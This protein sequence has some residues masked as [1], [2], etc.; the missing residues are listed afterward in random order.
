M[1]SDSYL[2]CSQRPPRRA[3]VFKHGTLQVKTISLPTLSYPFRGPRTSRI[4]RV[5]PRRGVRDA[6]ETRAADAAKSI[7]SGV[8]NPRLGGAPA[9]QVAVSSQTRRGARRTHPVRGHDQ[10]DY[11]KHGA[12]T[13]RDRG[14]PPHLW[15]LF[16]VSCYH[17]VCLGS[18]LSISAGFGI[19]VLM[20][21]RS[22]GP[23][24]HLWRLWCL[25]A[26]LQSTYQNRS[27]Q[28]RNQWR[29]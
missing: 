29:V 12:P 20:P 11:A 27:V 17:R 2:L 16:C 4:G 28:Y 8:S 18:V 15:H 7:R 25:A 3:A 22:S 10:D 6:P 23:Q 1:S 24:P 21:L 9:L 5:L 14:R 26:R 13:R 19:S